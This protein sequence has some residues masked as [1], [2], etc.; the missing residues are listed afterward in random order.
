MWIIAPSFLI[1]WL[2]LGLIAGLAGSDRWPSIV[3]GDGMVGPP[4]VCSVVRWIGMA[5]A[6]VALWRVR[7]GHGA[8]HGHAGGLSP[9]AGTQ[10]G[11]KAVTLS[12]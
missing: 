3:S 6:A 5:R 1:C 8:A 4:A 10:P 11:H 7:A 12:G 9:D 2:E